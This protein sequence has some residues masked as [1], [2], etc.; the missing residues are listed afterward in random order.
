MPLGV[1]VVCLGCC[2]VPVLDFGEGRSDLGVIVGYGDGVV[3]GC[4]LQAF[5]WLGWVEV[6][7]DLD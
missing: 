3:G 4:G 5:Q 1:L 6:Q 7:V 2:F